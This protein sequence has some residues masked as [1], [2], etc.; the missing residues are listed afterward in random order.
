MRFV[1]ITFAALIVLTVTNCCNAKAWRDIVPLKSTRADVERLFGPP[2]GPLPTYYLPDVTVDFGYSSCRCGEKC[3][4]DDWNVPPDTVT[5]IRV[6]MKG[7]VKLA[8][9]NIDLTKFKKWPGDEDVP[10]SFFYKNDEDG[11]A[12]EAGGGDVSALIYGPEAK[13][14][15]LR[16]PRSKRQNYKLNCLPISAFIDCSSELIKPGDTVECKIKLYGETPRRVIWRAPPGVSVR[17]KSAVSVKVRL[18]GTRREMIPIV[19]RVVSPNICLDEPSVRLRVVKTK[20]PPL[21]KPH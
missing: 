1:H 4:N 9:L 2:T 7:V 21:P 8:D 11:F 18:A 20:E 5:V 13:Y 14:D 10:G 15:Y 12:I 19:A 6:G 16:C 17:R 3:K